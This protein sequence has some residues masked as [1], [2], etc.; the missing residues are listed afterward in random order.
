[1]NQYRPE[2]FLKFWKD[3]LK[4][5]LHMLKVCKIIGYMTYL[6]LA[7]FTQM[8]L[9]YEKMKRHVSSH[10]NWHTRWLDD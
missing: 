1:M 6:F 7:M 2:S 4:I 9:S 3:I 5:D 8:C 10:L